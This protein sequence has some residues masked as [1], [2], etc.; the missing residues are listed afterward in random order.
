MQAKIPKLG[1]VLFLRGNMHL[2]LQE[3]NLDP[4]AWWDHNPYLSEEVTQAT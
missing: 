2:R 4:Q 1:L 3:D